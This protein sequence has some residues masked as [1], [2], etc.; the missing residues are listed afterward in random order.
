MFSLTSFP[1]W[2]CAHAVGPGVAEAAAAAAANP[3]AQ[4]HQQSQSQAEAVR[5]MDNLLPAWT[6]TACGPFSGVGLVPAN[7]LPQGS[8]TGD[9]QCPTA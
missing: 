4:E 9:A 6:A 1:C 3:D 2:T 7:S 5:L 8:G